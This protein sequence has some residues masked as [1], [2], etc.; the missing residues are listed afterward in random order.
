ML[1]VIAFLL[2]ILVLS[3][4]NARELLFTIAFK[5]ADILL[6]PF[7]LFARAKQTTIIFIQ[8]FQVQP[9]STAWTLAKFLYNLTVGLLGI[10]F[11]LWPIYLIYNEF[12]K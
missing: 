9:V 3:N 11:I 7:A 1:Y 8:S 10:A 4:P 5:I 6:L 12:F 2:L